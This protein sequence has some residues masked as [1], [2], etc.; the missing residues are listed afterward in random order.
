ML[1]GTQRQIGIVAAAGLEAVTAMGARLAEDHTT[2]RQLSEGLNGL[3]PRL[4]VSIPQTN[5]VQVDLTGTG[6]DS[7]RWV[8]DLEA[9]GILTRPLGERRLRLVTHR[10]IGSDDVARAIAAFRICL[11]AV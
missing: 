4:A 7:A 6:R 5:I 8:K 9:A 2:A 3:D 11:D 1:G 10:H